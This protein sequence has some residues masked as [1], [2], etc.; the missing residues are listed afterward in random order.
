MSVVYLDCCGDVYLTAQL[1]K[2]WNVVTGSPVVTQFVGRRDTSGIT[3]PSASDRLEKTV[4]SLATYVVGMAFK[5]DSLVATDLIT[6]REGAVDHIIVRA[7][8]TGAIEVLTAPSAQLAITAAGIIFAGIYSYIEILATIHDSTGV[9]EM[10]LNGVN[11]LNETAQDTRNGGTLG[12][13]DN[14]EI[15]GS[16]GNLTIDDFYIVET[17]G[18]TAPQNTKLGD[19]RI[20]VVLPQADGVT[21]DWPVLNPTTPTTHFD[22]VEDA[23]PDDDSSFVASDAVADLELFDFVELPDPG[24]V[25]PIFGVQLGMYTRKEKSAARSIK[26]KTRSGG[27]NY[28]GTT[29]PLLLT[30]QYLFQTWDEDP[31][32]AADWIEANINLAEF[33]IEI[34]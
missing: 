15:E 25:S 20:D 1:P 5:L 13:I 23:T 33:G 10:D 29:Q 11:L 18:G 16:T 4:P 19:T 12:E 27:T 30:Y 31:D 9:I 8:A 32:T 26:G 2:R 22:K 17:I 24:G 7:T 3:L 6:L 14:I 21:N 34:G 28:S